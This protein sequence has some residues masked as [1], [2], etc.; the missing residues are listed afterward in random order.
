[1]EDDA[2]AP[3]GIYHARIEAGGELR[4]RKMVLVK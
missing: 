1:M 3:S 4:S 2:A